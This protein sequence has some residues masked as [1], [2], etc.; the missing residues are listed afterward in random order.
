MTNWLGINIG[1]A[2][3]PPSGSWISSGHKAFEEIDLCGDDGDAKQGHLCVVAKGVLK[4]T[5]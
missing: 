4:L 5:A 2:T 1:D 3:P